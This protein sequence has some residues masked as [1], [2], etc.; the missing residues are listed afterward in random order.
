MHQKHSVRYP[1]GIDTAPEVKE[2]MPSKETT[3][4]RCLKNLPLKKEWRC[5]LCKV[6]VTSKNDLNAHLRGSKHKSSL[7]VETSKASRLGAKHTGF[8]LSGTS[9]SNHGK[10]E[11]KCTKE[12]GSESE[13]LTE[14]KVSN[15]SLFIQ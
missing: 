3:E 13:K 11:E 2:T 4:K 9:K 14:S 1:K 5:D 8:S 10:G 7:E 12:S 15:C 6:T